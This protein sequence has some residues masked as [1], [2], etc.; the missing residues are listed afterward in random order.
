MRLIKTPSVKIAKP[1]FQP[2]G[3][4]TSENYSKYITQHCQRTKPSRNWKSALFHS[5]VKLK[6]YLAEGEGKQKREAGAFCRPGQAAAHIKYSIK[7]E[8]IS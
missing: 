5:F 6:M 8:S 3:L 4:I 2:N 7:Q 1:D